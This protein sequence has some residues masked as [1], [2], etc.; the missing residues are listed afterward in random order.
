MADRSEFSPDAAHRELLRAIRRLREQ[1]RHSKGM[2]RGTIDGALGHAPGYLSRVLSGN[3]QL[4]CARLFEILAVVGEEPADF[5]ARTFPLLEPP[6]AVGFLPTRKEASKRSSRLPIRDRLLTW[7]RHASVAADGGVFDGD[8]AHL[9]RTILRNQDEAYALA[10]SWLEPV[11]ESAP[12]A[13]EPE[14]ASRLCE[15]LVILGEVL[16]RRGDRNT[17]ADILDLAFRFERPLGRPALRAL[18]YRTGVY[19]LSD[20]GDLDSALMFAERAERLAQAADDPVGVP[21]AL[22]LRALISK[23]LGFP[24]RALPLLRQCGRQLQALPGDHRHHRTAV[25]VTLA[26]IHL[27]AGDLGQASASLTVAEGL[28]V[29]RDDATYAQWLAA[30]GEVASLEGR[31]E[32]AEARFA[33]AKAIYGRVGNPSDR[34]VVLLCEVLHLFRAGDLPALSSRVEEITALA[35]HVEG[36]PIGQAALLEVARHILRG[37]LAEARIRESLAA[38]RHG[39]MAA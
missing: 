36:N 17:A 18:V 29:R 31:S 22:Y 28:L 15:V 9:T 10:V 7:G 21:R 27:E 26:R 39:K 32:E 24:D 37:E 14:S 19:L 23:R 38:L 20:L 5:F 16:R 1:A 2:Q 33:E 6:T 3:A 12:T 25:A 13:M 11:T 35:E 8:P 34:A 30:A 4:T